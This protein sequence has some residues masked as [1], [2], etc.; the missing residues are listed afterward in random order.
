MFSEIFQF[1]K[2]RSGDVN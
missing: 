2:T 1:T